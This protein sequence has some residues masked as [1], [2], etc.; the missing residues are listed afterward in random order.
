MGPARA[1]RGG[2]AFRERFAP[3]ALVSAAALLL[4]VL[5]SNIFFVGYFVDDAWYLLTARA[6]PS[7][8]L[9]RPVPFD[10]SLADRFPGLPLL[11]SPFVRLFAPASPCLRIFPLSAMLAA[12]LLFG[13]LERRRLGGWWAPLSA[14]LF[15]FNATAV[16]YAGTLMAEPA[17]L[18]AAL[19][20][21]WLLCE[22]P[23]REGAAAALLALAALLRPQGALLL[24]AAALSGLDRKSRARTLRTCAAAGAAFAILL[25]A[26]D[27]R[28]GSLT[29][30][31][32]D[33]ARAQRGV[34]FL[35]GWLAGLKA[36]L[37]E[38]F[39]GTLFAWPAVRGALARRLVAW[40]VIAGS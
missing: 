8:V 33:A 9:G 27:W 31:F 5:A 35:P 13:L 21:A 10:V 16:R 6:L 3:V 11:L 39:P 18:A 7:L 30:Y 36:A 22:R 1:A 32:V 37:G 15:L 4:H 29:S 25:A 28:A 17:F 23:E 12:G 2:P 40:G 19:G 26:A 14:A 38:T 24:A 20:A 34:A